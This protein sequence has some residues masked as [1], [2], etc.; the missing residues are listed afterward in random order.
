MSVD[1]L[2]SPQGNEKN[3]AGP[4]LQVVREW[5]V[6]WLPL[7]LAISTAACSWM[8]YQSEKEVLR[9]SF[10]SRVANAFDG[11]RENLSFHGEV[12]QSMAELFEIDP[13]VTHDDFVRIAK[14]HIRQH[15]SIKALSWT[16]V[17]EH[18]DRQNHESTLANIFPGYSLKQWQP[19]NT[20]KTK[21]SKWS[22]VY[23]PVSY[24]HPRAGNEP[25]FG[26]D[27]ASN[28]TRA[29]AL[30][31]ARDTGQN[32]ATARIVLAQAE[33][34]SDQP[35]FLIFVPIYHD[36]AETVQQRQRRL[37]GFCSGVF[38]VND[39]VN[40]VFETRDVDGVQLQIT[41]ESAVD[42]NQQLLFSNS[43]KSSPATKNLLSETTYQVGGREWKFRWSC[44]DDHIAQQQG[45]GPWLLLLGGTLLSGLLGIT[46]NSN[47]KMTRRVQHLADERTVALRTTQEQLRQR[48]SKLE[49]I[50]ESMPLALAYSDS[51]RRITGVNPAF[52]ET[53]GYAEDEIIGQSSSVLYADQHQFLQQG[54]LRFNKEASSDLGRL[55]FEIEYARKSGSRFVGET[56]GTVVRDSKGAVIGMLCLINDVTDRKAADRELR[57]SHFAVEHAS[58][59][60]FWIR[61]D[62]SFSNANQ[63]ATEQLGYQREELLQMTV[64]DINLEYSND[65]WPEH[66]QET[67]QQGVLKFETVHYRKD[68]TTYQSAVTK[69]FLSFE[70]QEVIFATARDIS[71]QK[72]ADAALLEAKQLAEESERRFRRLANSASTLCWVTEL[73]S[74][75]SWLNTRW[76]KY[77][78]RPLEEQTGFGWLETVHPDDREL[79]KSAYMAAFEKQSSFALDYRLRRHDGTYRWHTADAVPRLDD[80]GEFIGFVGMSID[81]HDARQSR[82]ALEA[83]ELSLKNTSESLQATLNLLGTSDGV[84]DWTVGSQNIYYAPGFRRLFGFD[85]DDVDGFPDVLETFESRIHPND[86]DGFWQAINQSLEN[87]TPFVFEFQVRCKD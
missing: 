36:L 77:C 64:S 4:L 25:A 1:R 5:S 13:K 57:L 67:K 75:C 34:G 65:T 61:E 11:L 48:T 35:A 81:T 32:V 18:A 76:L 69:H 42:E 78:G 31:K 41:D 72:A 23:F 40:H 63:K 51:N 47:A 43:S 29:L 9:S 26:I 87:K 33:E 30:E 45:M 54:N 53:F 49:S 86:K 8:V 46:L 24:I 70:G 84:W 79:A 73:D 60:V 71:S 85:G 52:T 82:Q 56:V 66:W 55:P 62:G 7:L 10:E 44:T 20:W 50:F 6:I 74:T 3:L 37:I 58:D 12:V 28:P 83:S 27:L 21:A 22:D 38:N 15:E 16:P 2:P 14:R 19:G 80:D 59:A 39:I 17:V 68:G